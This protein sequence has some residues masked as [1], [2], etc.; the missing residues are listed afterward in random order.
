LERES[1]LGEREPWEGEGRES[2]RETKRPKREKLWEKE[3]PLMLFYFGDWFWSF[4][5]EMF[6]GYAKERQEEGVFKCINK[7][8]TLH[9]VLMS[10][11]WR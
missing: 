2:L 1:E 6:V 8:S 3:T 7:I 10:C 11:I 4:F 9:R 5:W